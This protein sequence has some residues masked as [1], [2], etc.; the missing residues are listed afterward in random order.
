MQLQR[1]AQDMERDRDTRADTHSQMLQRLGQDHLL[2]ST[3]HSQKPGWTGALRPC[4]HGDTGLSTLGQSRSQAARRPMGRVLS[5]P[6]SAH[7]PTL[8]PTGVRSG[9]SQTHEQRPT[10]RLTHM[11]TFQGRSKIPTPVAMATQLGAVAGAL[12]GSAYLAETPGIINR[13]L[14]TLRTSRSHT[15]SWRRRQ[16]EGQSL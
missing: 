11:C 6:P 10:Q 1:P 5:F 8:G 9:N 4:L 7:L 3:A 12:I 14:G 15:A 13:R 16:W 2:P